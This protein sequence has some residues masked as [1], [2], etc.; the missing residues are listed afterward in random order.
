HKH[1]VC[2]AINTCYILEKKPHNCYKTKGLQ[3]RNLPFFTYV[4]HP[5][6]GKYIPIRVFLTQ[7][8][9]SISSL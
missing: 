4:T 1:F 2:E 8:D 5:F 9:S 7:F 6:L 3:G